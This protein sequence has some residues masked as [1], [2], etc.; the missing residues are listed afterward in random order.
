MTS[1]INSRIIA[2]NN[3][4]FTLLKG[5]QFKQWYKTRFKEIRKEYYDSDTGR[6]VEIGDRIQDQLNSPLHYARE[7][8]YTQ[9]AGQINPVTNKRES[10][11]TGDIL[12]WTNKHRWSRVFGLH[13]INTPSNLLR[14]N[15]Q[16]LPFLGRFQFQMRHM[17]AEVDDL[18]EKGTFKGFTK[19][20][21]GAARSVDPTQIF[22]KGRRKKYINPEAASEANARIQAGWLLW[23][24]AVNM[25]IAGKFTGG[26]SRDYKIN[27]ERE[28]ITGWQPYSYK[29]EDGRYVSLNRLD[30]IF[31]PFFIAADMYER[32]S[33]FYRYNEDMPEGM[34]SRELELALGTVSTL[35]RNL[36]SKFYT[37]NILETANFLMSDD[38]L[39]HRA[40]EYAAISAFSRGIYKFM[41]LSGGLRYIDRVNDDWEKQLWDFNDR[42][43]RIGLGDE[44]KVMPRRNMLG[45]KI[46]RKNGWL[47]G[48]GG[49]TGLWSTPFAMTKWKNATIA[50]FFEGRDFSY[51]PPSKKGLVDIGVDLR[52][53]RRT[54]GQ[55][56]YD[57]W[58]ELKQD[59]NFKYKGKDYKLKDFIEKMIE[60]KTSP[61]HKHPSGKKE[62]KMLFFT[63]QKGY[64]FQ[65][66]QILQWI[67]KAERIAYFKMVKEFP[68]I[69]ST[70][71][72]NAEQIN[73][74][75][76]DAES[77]I[78]ILLQ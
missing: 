32:L 13:F 40:P 30:P 68:Q 9:K 77:A 69:K 11:I 3:I 17:L 43:T 19:K 15:F 52:S 51:R 67:H 29:T 56:A 70:A 64:D 28:S 62:T 73:Q 45:E 41:P 74:G 22:V 50:N 39:F 47:F 46:D 60:D 66:N 10:Q 7:G 23:T 58:L 42:M 12:S 57:R 33:E 31:M 48:L 53:I 20:T 55:T 25:A 14:W 65:Q 18:A 36:T 75:Y 54:D 24:G 61:L 38:F 71:I 76:K 49:E 59:V 5:H 63:S 72:S 8:S 6:A 4:D 21:L 37:K 78:Q 34:R 16:H 2:E 26:G 27:R 1:I 35:V 44:S